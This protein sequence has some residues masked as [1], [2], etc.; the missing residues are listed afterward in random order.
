MVCVAV[1]A[2]II[3]AVNPVKTITTNTD[4]HTESEVY[5]G[6]V[7][8]D[9][10]NCSLPVVKFDESAFS[11][12]VPN[13]WI[14][15]VDGG[16]VSIMQDESNTT[17]AFL[18]TAKLDQSLSAE[19]F[20][21]LFKEIFNKTV[22]SAG[23]TFA[24]DEIIA[25]D[26]A[27]SGVITASLNGVDMTGTMLVDKTEDF[28]TL[29][30]YW[31]PKQSIATEEPILTEIT[32][33]FA[34]QRIIDD[35]MLAAVENKDQPKAEDVPGGFQ[36]YDGRFFALNKPANYSVTTETDSGIDLTRSDGRAGF[37]YAY[38]T[39]AT[40]SYTTQSWAE[41]ALPQYAKIQQAEISSG[42]NIASPINGQDVAEFDFSGILNGNTPVNGKITVGIINA[43]YYGIGTRYFSAFW[44]IQVATPEVW[45]D[46]K[47]TLQTLQDSLQITDIGNT[48]KNTLLPP[49]RPIESMGGS[50]ITS[51]SSS[52]SDSLEKSSEEKW[53]DAMR[54]YETVSSP[55]TGETYDVPQNSWSS[56]GP[57]G[58]GYYRQLPDDSLEKLQ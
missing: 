1:A 41:K 19:N 38:V 11:I 48:R 58:P 21:S 22:S 52:Y 36:A 12:G 49:N 16:T 6:Q 47:S 40:G 37:S 20:L 14:Y 44:G 45:P 30:S 31:A 34:R 46:A 43:P 39:G 35:T 13:G 32:N 25:D 9:N 24:L 33:C 54:G 23:G 3:F 17:A 57:E 42:R 55:S 10:P 15:E 27:A 29:K 18:Y 26:A 7:V 51:K 50:S 4:P 2:A 8:N 53:S 28:V 5:T 56:Y